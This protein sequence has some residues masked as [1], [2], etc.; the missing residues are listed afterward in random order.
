M[1]EKIER[2]SQ[3]LNAFFNL[4]VSHGS[5]IVGFVTILDVASKV[6]CSSCDPHSA[7]QVAD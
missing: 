6:G 2:L 5:S 4:K 3:P 1:E 7:N